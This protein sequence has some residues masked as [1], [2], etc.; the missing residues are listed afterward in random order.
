MDFSK[1]NSDFS[2]EIINT[3]RPDDHVLRESE[4]IDYYR[5]KLEVKKMDVRVYVL[6]SKYQKKGNSSLK[7]L[8]QDNEKLTVS[9]DHSS[10]TIKNGDKGTCITQKNKL[11]KF[12][13]RDSDYKFK[14]LI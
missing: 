8:Q 3:S 4:S 9:K 12:I 1:R 13:K 14:K 2:Q 10:H 5:N 6:I 7:L 11:T